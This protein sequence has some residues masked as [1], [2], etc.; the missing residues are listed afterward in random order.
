MNN[1]QI[2]EIKKTHRLI[3]EGI[4]IPK[5]I[6][7]ICDDISYPK[8][9]NVDCFNI[10][11]RSFWFKHRNNC[12]V[13]VF[14][15]FPPGGALYDVGGGNGYV[16]LGLKNNGFD[17]VLFEPRIEGAR[18]AKSR[19]L[20]PVICAT[21]EGSGFKEKTIPAIGLFDVLEHIKEDKEYLRKIKSFLI[22][23]GRLYLTVPAYRIL[24]SIEDDLANHYRRYTLKELTQKI[25]S[26]GYEIDY[27]TYF[28]SILPLPIFLFR[29]IPSKI[30][31]R[32]K[33]IFKQ[34]QKEHN[35]KQKILSY[36]LNWYLKR[37]LLKIKKNKINF[38]ASC[39]IVARSK[40]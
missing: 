38:G 22:N 19:G 17:T 26:I 32:K 39:L 13:E 1:F 7:N 3:E 16:A 8:G 29:T 15:R 10:E 34:A 9:G 24:W 18:N 21:L 35:P 5:N 4:W 25:K 33:S 23:N 40:S 20:N 6:F 12:L 28:F 27:A 36:L 30:K 14:R 11:E 2:E 37:E 31:F